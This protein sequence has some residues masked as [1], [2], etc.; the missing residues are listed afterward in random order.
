[1]SRYEN[2]FDSRRSTDEDASNQDFE[3]AVNG[4]NLAHWDRVFCEVMNKYWREKSMI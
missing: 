2:H 1:M 4:P 3:I